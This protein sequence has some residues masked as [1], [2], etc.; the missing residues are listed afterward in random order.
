MHEYLFDVKFF[1]AI[2]VRADSETEARAMLRAELDC[3]T[4]NFGPWGSGPDEGG[5][6]LGEASQ[7]GDADLVEVDGAVP[8]A[9]K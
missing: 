3:C 5:L 4:A 2:R 6:I 9:G 8:G 1:A 7:D